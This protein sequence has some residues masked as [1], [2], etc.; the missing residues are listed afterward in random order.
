MV[1]F[2]RSVF[3]HRVRGWGGAP[4]LALAALALATTA[5][6]GVD[7]LDDQLRPKNLVAVE[8]GR[9]YRSGQISPRLIRP[10][11]EELRIGKVVWMLHYDASRPSHRAEREAI[12]ALGIERVNLP[13]RG[14]GTGD[15]GR[16]ADAV[17]EVAQ[18]QRAGVPVLVHCAAGSRRSAAV[19]AMY[20]LLVQRRS[21][22]QAFRELDRIG[23]RPV[24]ESP[25]LAYL[26]EHMGELARL[27]AARGVIERAPFPL[28]LLRPPP[29]GGPSARLARLVR[30]APRA[31]L[32]GL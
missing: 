26:N 10:V 7:A 20:Q 8:P 27:L 11:L 12:E 6:A 32:L 1:R 4:R 17:A 19:I 14:N 9:L 28:P 5:A 16:Y 29:P 25:L 3:A 30:G 24:A 23:K 2:V 21:P 22:E 13:L 18:A 15:I 31:G